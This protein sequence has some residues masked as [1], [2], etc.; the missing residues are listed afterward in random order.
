WG[1]SWIT[2]V[3]FHVR[4]ID[5]VEQHA[6][7]R[8]PQNQSV[9]TGRR[10]LTIGCR[11]DKSSF[12]QALVENPKSIL[13][14]PQELDAVAASRTKHEQVAR[15]RILIQVRLHQR[16][17]RIESLAHV[18]RQRTDKNPSR[19]REAKH[20]G[21]SKTVSSRRSSSASN[22]GLTRSTRPWRSTTSSAVSADAAASSVTGMNAGKGVGAERLS[23]DRRV[24]TGVCTDFSRSRCAI[25]RFQA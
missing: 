1:G 20:D 16:R 21:A 18:R 14:P 12:L 19:Q 8:R 17:Q 10:T 2:L 3:P 25:S 9:P 23:E 22:P 24:A 7:F 13:V 5:A 15:Q 11:Q 6:Q 4:K